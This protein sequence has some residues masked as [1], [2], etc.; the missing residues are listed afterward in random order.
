MRQYNSMFDPIYPE[1]SVARATLV[2][3]QIQV[4]GVTWARTENKMQLLDTSWG[5]ILVEDYKGTEKIW[6]NP[7]NVSQYPCNLILLS[8]QGNG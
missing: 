1:L 7:T 8:T 2:I 3:N 4:N 6:I 5:Y